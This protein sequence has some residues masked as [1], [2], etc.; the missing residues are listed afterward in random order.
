MQIELSEEMRGALEKAAAAAGMSVSDYANLL[1]REQVSIDALAA[2]QRVEAVERLIEHMRSA[3][4]A[5]GRDGRGWRE[6]IHEG[7]AN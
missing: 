5:S 6:F 3:K 4:S 7:H 2:G 1:I